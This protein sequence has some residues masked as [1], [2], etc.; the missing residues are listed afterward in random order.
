MYKPLLLTAF[1]LPFSLI[2]FQLSG[3]ELSNSGVINSNVYPVSYAQVGQ[4]DSDSYFT[5]STSLSSEVYNLTS[6][7]PPN[8]NPSSPM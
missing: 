6:S 3:K 4:G 5:S 2:Q 8:P 1:G 7:D